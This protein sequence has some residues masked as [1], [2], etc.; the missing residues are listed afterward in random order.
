MIRN[1][2]RSTNF[3]KDWKLAY[4][5][6]TLQRKAQA[7]GNYRKVKEYD[8][9]IEGLY[10]K[11][12]QF[13]KEY[14]RIIQAAS[15]GLTGLTSDGRQQKSN[16]QKS[17]SMDFGY[18]R[19]FLNILR[20]L[21]GDKN[22]TS[23]EKARMR[24]D[25]EFTGAKAGYTKAQINKAL[26]PY[27]K[28]NPLNA[29]GRSM[30]LYQVKVLQGSKVTANRLVEGLADAKRT[31]TVIAASHGSGVRVLIIAPGGRVVATLTGKARINPET[32]S[33]QIIV[34][35]PGRDT[36]ISRTFR[37]TEK[38]ARRE[39]MRRAEKTGGNVRLVDSLG[40]NIFV[41]RGE[42]GNPERKASKPTAKQQQLHKKF[43]G[44]QADRNTAVNASV[45]APARTSKLGGLK[46]VKLSN[47][48]KLSFNEKRAFLMEGTDGKM[49]V[50]GVR[51]A[52]PKSLEKAGDFFDMGK[53]DQIGYITHKN[54]IENG[55]TFC[56]VHKM[57][58]N[59]GKRP[60]LMLD[61]QGFPLI[62][63]GSYKIRRVGIV[64]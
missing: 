33:Y 49:Y 8:D 12:G 15:W 58:E 60:H 23:A 4:K 32:E 51:F 35:M 38:A 37:G 29:G 47:G 59:G 3:A 31:A 56:Y 16:P 41:V 2:P 50:G 11:Y 39:S 57:G 53:I 30:E 46:F 6:G 18:R 64:K 10:S 27:H 34:K 45:Y 19:A 62:V 40:N 13:T 42:R 25:A 5:I 1:N 7:A 44:R 55:E 14:S 48:R 43:Q 17:K 26:A 20:T 28:A 9:A 52:P 54:H 24:G 22:L 21:K 61:Y 63:G 36:T